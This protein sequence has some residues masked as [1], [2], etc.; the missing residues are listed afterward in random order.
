MRRP[1]GPGG[2][3]LTQKELE[4]MRERGELD[5]NMNL[6]N[7][8]ALSSAS[9]SKSASLSSSSTLGTG[10]TTLGGAG[11]SEKGSKAA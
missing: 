8:D 2:R 3:F 11:K 6:I 7:K 5:D 1:R 9:S 10:G 4:E